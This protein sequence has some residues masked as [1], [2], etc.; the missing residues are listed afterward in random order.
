MTTTSEQS[1]G[2]RAAHAADDGRL[3]A[4]A[5][6]TLAVL[7][8][9]Q[10]I[11]ALDFSILNVALPKLG[12]DL[13]M[14]PSDLQWAVTAFAL[15]SGGF[16]LFFGRA[17]DIYGR[18]RLFLGGV[19]L[20]T[21]ASV[22][23]TLG[24]NP[25]SFLA[26]RALQGLGAAVVV[27]VGMSL[28]T[29][30]FP[31]GPLRNRALAVNG[32]LLSLGYTVGM[33]LGGSMTEGLGWR[34]TMGLLA[35]AG[36]LVAVAAMRLI[37]EPG[38]SE[39]T[40]RLDL[41]GAMTVTGGL[42]ALIYGASTASGEHPNKVVVA[43]A[44]LVGVLLLAAF[45]LVERRAPQPL[46]SLAMLRLR[47][48]A[49]GNLGGLT[50]FAMMSSL[51]FLLT[52][53]LQQVLHLSALSTGLFFGAQGIVLVA[54]GMGASRLI[55]RLGART[56]LTGGLAVQAVGTFAL[57]AL[58]RADASAWVPLAALLLASVGHMS[59][60]V[61]YGVNATAGLPD[62]MQGLAGGLITS[63]QQIGIT[64]GTPVLSAVCS[65]RLSQQQDAGE[66]F[67]LSLLGGVRLGTLVD[68]GVVL[69]IA[70]LVGFGLAARRE[71]RGE[72]R[73]AKPR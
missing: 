64:I 47:G 66:S 57:L 27:P 44:L 60:V 15:P 54:T 73:T 35:V 56:V 34:S 51:I 63:A 9:A 62:D 26:A 39:R 18:R 67:E 50:T 5:A 29:T 36:A 28:L 30:I 43:G 48:V 40:A 22:L 32:A 41:P 65:Y 14:A 59:A 33:V 37:A 6:L 24:W 2:P 8:G 72:G 12:K 58:V 21:A 71:G 38:R 16:L 68:A 17:A 1:A 7:C 55:G 25:G 3:G 13:G 31:E 23:A 19:A 10:F 53:Y 49:F 61:S 46:V 70:L 20:F 11:I 42:L 45:V 4:R 69:L 52:L